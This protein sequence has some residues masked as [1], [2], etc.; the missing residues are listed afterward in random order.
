M[1]TLLKNY[2]LST[3]GKTITCTDIST[4]R[5]DRLL[6][7][8]DTTTNKI[9]YNFA[10]STVS[11]AMVA[12][13]VVTLSVLQGGEANTDKLQIIYDT[14]PG[15]TAF[16]DST[17]AIQVLSSVLPTGAATSANQSTEI[18]SLSSI[19]TNTGNGST[20]ANQTNGNQQSKI[21]D[22][23]NVA[24]VVAGDTGFNGVAT[25]SAGDSVTFTSSGTGA[26][27]LGP[28][29]VEG[30]NTVVVHITSNSTAGL[31]WAAQWSQ[32]NGGTF[33]SAATWLALNS[34]TA[35]PGGIGTTNTQYYVSPANDNY[36]QLNISALTSG[37]IS[38]TITLSNR[39]PSLAAGVVGSATLTGS[40]VPTTGYYMAGK[41]ASGNLAGLQTLNGVADAISGGGN[42]GVGTWSYNGSAWDRTRTANGAANTTGT[43]LSGS[44]IL[45]YDSANYQR[46]GVANPNTSTSDV[47][48]SAL[49]TA[50][51]ALPVTFTTTS[52]VAV[53]TTDVA[54]YRWVS[55]QIS[56][57][58]TA[59]NNQ[60]QVSND[61]TN[62]FNAPLVLTTN[63]VNAVSSVGNATGV[64]TGPL[65]G[66]YFRIN[67]TGITGG[68][69]AGTVIFS[70]SPSVLNTFGVAAS[71]LGTWAISSSTATGS[72][73]PANAH[74]MGMLSS[75]GNLVG[76][77]TAQAQSKT[78]NAGGTSVS[79]SLLTYN[80][81][82]FDVVTGIGGVP[83]ANLSPTASGGWA[84]YFAN[85]VTTAVTVS[86]AAGKFGGY[87][88]INLNSTPVYLQCFDT[89]G[90][91][92]LGTTA[93]TFV[94]ALPANST[95]ANGVAANFEIANGANLAN[96]LKVAATTT[97][98]GAT[99]VST[100]VSGSIWYK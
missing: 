75:G 55:V 49:L 43:G 4:V 36:F 44:G 79:S 81:S 76:L 34:S 33:T 61:N 56:S 3:S 71:Q 46:V 42:L 39:T 6:L 67:V 19:A 83:N 65:Y 48:D 84:S 58:G 60:F 50:S 22:G 87:S 95:A 99:A 14:L 77:S 94:V 80:G 51:G 74:Y 32:T 69:T 47:T 38:G 54:N 52:A 7:I 63:T 78:S 8:V 86:G 9:L 28:W 30:Y 29:K 16:G 90:A 1:K 35:L 40:T 82:T 89:T 5:L 68:T 53:A 31:A 70:S 15:D 73:I 66:R 72:T 93:P 17:D 100:G 96:G 12:T 2:T 26:Q 91:V 57:Q 11:T 25:A 62:W 64:Y 85:A 88:L 24:N 21:T 13:N 18:T 59:S 23:T 98:N 20:A 45:G 97:A 41:D 37:T 27:V 10:D 92:T